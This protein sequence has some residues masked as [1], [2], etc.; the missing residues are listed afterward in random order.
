MY[1]TCV[2]C[3]SSLGQ[4]EAIENFPVGRRLAFDA[5]KGRLWAV[6]R[7]CGRWNL[8]PIEERW[9]AIEECERL[10]RSTIIR[11]STD[12]IGLAKI[13]EGT[14]LIRI[15]KPLRPE[16]A[17]WRYTRHFNR[18]RMM[19]YVGIGA[20][21]GVA[22]TSLLFGGPVFTMMPAVAALLG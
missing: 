15:G 22:G 21:I 1:S 6:C 7:K 10:F 18:R 13:R 8:T 14:D 20:T 17:A 11:A 2:F 16:F 3:H 4:N 5:G 19:S 9:E 12:E